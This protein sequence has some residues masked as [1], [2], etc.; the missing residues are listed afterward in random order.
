VDNFQ[1]AKEHFLDGIQ[2]L[3]NGVFKEAEREFLASLEL[4]PDR[5]STLT[6]LGA[7]QVKLKKYLEARAT[8]EKA[9]ALDGNNPEALLNLGLV[10][11]EAKDFVAALDHFD[12]A[13]KLDPGFAKAWS[14]IGS[15]FH[16]LR[17]YQSA[18]RAFDQALSLD[19]NYYEAWS[20]K[21]LTLHDLKRY[22]ESLL[23]HEKAISL[24]TQHADAWF[25]KGL[26]CVALKD[27]INALI[28]FRKTFEINPHHKYLLGDLV[29]TQLLIGDWNHLDEKIL[30][31]TKEINCGV[32][33]STPFP[34]LSASDE[35]QLHLETAKL[36]TNDKYPSNHSL[37][38]IPKRQPSKI[39]IGYFSPDFKD[40]PV[41]FLTAELF[42]LHDRD[43]FEVFAFSLQSV[44]SSNPVR[45]RLLAGF[46][47]FIEVEDK[48][49]QEIAQ[50]ARDH[51][52]DIAIDLCGH[53]Q[54]SRTGIFSY[55]AAPIQVNYLGYPGSLGADY[56]D[57][58]IADPSL[59]P[60]LDQQF[61]AEKVAY[62]PHSYMVDDSKRIPSS[63][64]FSKA[65]LHIP[66]NK[67]IFCCFNNS[68]KLNGATLDSWAKIISRV[69]N[70]V[71]WLSENNVEFRSNLLNEFSSRGIDPNQIIFAE[72]MESMGD[73][74]ARYQIA[75]LFLDTL[76]FNAHTT[77]VDA[78]K[79]GVPLITLAG[80]AFA[81]R[82][83]ASLLEAINLP[84][85]ITHS[86]EDYE[87]LAIS[88]AT[89]PEQMADLK[90]KLSDNRFTTPLFNTPLFAK[91]IE[92]AY[93]QMYQRYQEDL[94]PDHLYIN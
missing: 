93:Q 20:N 2:H 86:R 7:T 43:Q 53:T 71:L 33:A 77:A 50:L 70:S 68:Y 87:S 10:Y 29:H 23:S 21:G 90:K 47:Q 59:I 31:L 44:D 49:D 13:I 15:T 4:A 45:K 58:I 37:P 66:E 54:F 94:S 17:Q 51:E 39:R 84:E 78:L 3:E 73:H 36:W 34:M 18:L 22:K 30:T 42:E 32:H 11:K 62:L 9:I 24:N 26:T 25:N 40:H 69:P 65:E 46:D 52:I 79:A 82:V 14:N 55:R 76:P 5:P 63:R 28:C 16:D 85:L 64:S 61:Y 83:G 27:F 91:N 38:A 75:D 41:S 67:F 19:A 74:L 56:F 12:Q 92:A 1:K 72:R 8:C 89:N 60:K 88:L 48:S 6:N 80:K 35:P 81:G 57:Y